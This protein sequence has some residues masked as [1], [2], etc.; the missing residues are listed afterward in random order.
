MMRYLARHGRSLYLLCQILAF[1]AVCLPL[2]FAFDRNEERTRVMAERHLKEVENIRRRLDVS[3]TILVDIHFEG[4]EEVERREVTIEEY[5]DLL[6][7]MELDGKK[8]VLIEYDGISYELSFVLGD[9][10]EELSSIGTTEHTSWGLEAMM[11]KT[12]PPSNPNLE[13]PGPVTIAICD[14]GISMDHVDSV[15]EECF[16][17]SALLP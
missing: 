5:E 8:I 9:H 7:V 3:R 10:N 12:F 13:T 4:T 15:S 17:A 1:L 6:E 11:G 2:S 16:R 14:S